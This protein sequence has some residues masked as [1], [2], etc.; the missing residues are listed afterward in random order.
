MKTSIY[1]VSSIADCNIYYSDC[2]TLN[3]D[4]DSPNDMLVDSDDFLNG[5]ETEKDDGDVAIIHPDENVPRADDGMSLLCSLRDA[6]LLADTW[7]SGGHER[8]S[9]DPP[10]RTTPNPGRRSA[11][12]AHRKLVKSATETPR[13]RLR[14][15][16]ASMVR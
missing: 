8:D 15:R 1:E 16:G 10:P 2:Q 6:G 7:F 13:A 5:A 3:G 14:M 11:H 12:M 4:I 9:P